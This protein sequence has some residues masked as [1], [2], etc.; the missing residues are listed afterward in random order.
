MYNNIYVSKAVA[1]KA[2]NYSDH[3]HIFMSI[4]RVK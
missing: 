3:P 2:L 1:Q 4:S